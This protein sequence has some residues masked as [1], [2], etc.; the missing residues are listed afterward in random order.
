M[1]KLGLVLAVLLALG[2]AAYANRVTVLLHVLGFYTDWHHP[3]APNR[4]VPWQQGPQAADTPLAQRPPNVIVIMADDLGYND[5][6][7]YGHGNPAQPTPAI[8]SLA[9]NGVR[10]DQGYAGNAVCAPSRAT[11]MT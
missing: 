2:A 3:R 10:F 6:S 9:K 1:K 5:V 7:L 11:M 4:P 8:D